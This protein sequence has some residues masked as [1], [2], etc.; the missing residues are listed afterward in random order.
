MVFDIHIML[1]LLSRTCNR[2][3]QQIV[4]YHE[5][6]FTTASAEGGAGLKVYNFTAGNY[7]GSL[8]E[9]KKTISSFGNLSCCRFAKG[10]F[11]ETMPNFDDDVCVAYIDVD[12]VLSTKDC[13]ENLRRNLAPKGTVFSQDAH[14]VKIRDLFA[15][16]EYWMNEVGCRPPRIEGLGVRRMIRIEFDH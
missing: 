14:L 7:L 5:E 8:E 4:V 1:N 6:H 3:V 9:V 2:R 15:D 11:S 16:E 10:W 13:I 12:L